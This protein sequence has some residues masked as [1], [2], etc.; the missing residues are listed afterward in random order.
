[1][2]CSNFLL[3]LKSILAI[4]LYVKVYLFDFEDIDSLSLSQP[5]FLTIETYPLYTTNDKCSPAPPGFEYAVDCLMNT[6]DVCCWPLLICP[7]L[8]IPALSSSSLMKCFLSIP[9]LSS[10][11]L[12]I[13]RLY[14]LVW[15]LVI[16]SYYIICQWFMHANHIYLECEFFMAWIFVIF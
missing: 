14:W 11:L 6:L 5:S 3:L 2:V 10:K 16:L 4:F 1:M 9:A 12:L 13:Y 15:F 8:Q 7:Y